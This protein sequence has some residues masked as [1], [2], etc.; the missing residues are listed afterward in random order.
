[1]GKE[2]VIFGYPLDGVGFLFPG[3]AYTKV[4]K[5]NHGEA[6][7]PDHSTSSSFSFKLY[8]VKTCDSSI[9]AMGN[10]A[11]DP[12]VVKI[13]SLGKILSWRQ[14]ETKQERAWYSTYVFTHPSTGD[15]C[16]VLYL[17]P[18][19]N[20]ESYEVIR[21]CVLDTRLARYSNTASERALGG[22]TYVCK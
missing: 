12:L 4:L 11:T 8:S 22:C 14:N 15:T 18:I 3:I 5:K 2:M 19:L 20:P 7:F 16:I 1:M 6:T 10:L 21:V 9:L 17:L 13:L